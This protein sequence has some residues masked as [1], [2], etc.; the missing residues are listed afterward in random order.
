MYKIETIVSGFTGNDTN[1]NLE[2]YTNNMQRSR[3]C[4]KSLFNIF[5]VI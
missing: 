3:K 5:L 4:L 1:E 2:F